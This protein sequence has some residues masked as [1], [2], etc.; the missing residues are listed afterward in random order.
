M[1]KYLKS[2]I[3]MATVSIM[4]LSIVGCGNGGDNN[5][6]ASGE[7]SSVITLATNA[8][9]PPYEYYEGQEIVGIDV[10]FINAIG[11]KLGKE[12]VI[13]DMAFDSIIPAIQSGKADI[14]MAGMTVTEDRLANVDF[15]E[16]YVHTSQAI[17]VNTDSD[18][19]KSSA[20]LEGKTIG[21]QL[22]T[23]G[24]TYAGDV[25]DKVE[26][27]NKGFEAAMALS[28]GKIDAV[29]IDESVAKA[30]AEGTE[31]LAVLD[32]PFTEEDYAIAVKKG[33]QE[34]V[35]ELN[36]AINELKEDGTLQSIV[37]KYIAE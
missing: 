26:R 14:G 19:I 12:I 23:T 17:I 32:E 15:T 28:Q 6:S 3:A 7:D 27:Y 2:I 29:V 4:A 36:K 11:E 35:D 9:F 16:T 22:G 18:A 21:V 10:D 13:E 1:K 37:D 34:L 5:S 25:T 31:N 30:L 20:D 24:D 8:E 33:N